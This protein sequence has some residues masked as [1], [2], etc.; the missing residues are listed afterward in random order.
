MSIS[1]VK[2]MECPVCGALVD[3]AGMEKY[4]LIR[5][6]NC[7]TDLEYIETELIEGGEDESFSNN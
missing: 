3:V 7:M 4:E 5:C 6:Y 1:E 2:E